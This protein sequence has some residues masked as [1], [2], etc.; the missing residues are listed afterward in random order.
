[1]FNSCSFA[2][3]NI[4]KEAYIF[5]PKKNK[6]IYLHQ[7]RSIY[8][9]KVKKKYVSKVNL[10]GGPKDTRSSAWIDGKARRK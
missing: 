4:K 8:V 3:R 9:S 5:T 1:M 2:C 10:N 6:H 7:K